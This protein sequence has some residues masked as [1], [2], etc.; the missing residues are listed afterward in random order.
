MTGTAREGI[1]AYNNS[2]ATDLSISSA[3]VTGSTYGIDARNNGSGS[4]SITT[5][6]GTVT[7]KSDDG[8]FA[9]NASK[10]SDLTITTAAVTGSAFG[11]AAINNGTGITSITSKGAV[12]GTSAGGISAVNAVGGTNVT[13]INSAAVTGSTLGIGAI[14]NGTGATSITSSGLVTGSSNGGIYALNSSTATGLTITSAAVTGATRGIDARNNGT[15]AT[16][17]TVNGAVTGSSSKAQGIYSFSNNTTTNNITVN[18]GGSVSA[19]SGKAIVMR[20]TAINSATVNNGG[21][22]TGSVDFGN[23]ANT[24]T[25]NSGGTLNVATGF[26]LTVDG[27]VV[28]NGTIN[29][30]NNV[31]AAPATITGNLSGGGQLLVDVNLVSNT[32]DKLNINGNVTGSTAVSINNI[33]TSP[34]TGNDIT[35]ITVGGTTT[36]GNFTVATGA[37]SGAFNYNILALTGKNWILKSSFTPV[38]S[39]FEAL[40]QNLLTMAKLPSLADRTYSRVGGTGAMGAN[41]GDTSDISTP[42]WVRYAG[43]YR[44]IDSQES[45]TGA[46]FDT[47]QWLAQAGVDLVLSENTN[48]S[49]VLGINTGYNQADTDVESTSGQS[50]IDTKGYNLGLTATWQSA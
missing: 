33:A 50:N 39:S 46:D 2:T 45:T 1:Y 41:S 43:G 5:T 20:G 23:T 14:N 11:I 34:A 21:S 13:I 8:I 31:I 30:R 28:N 27:S 18:N 4:T 47:K 12:T 49:F 19:T 17:I 36:A 37:V 35:L 9:I 44:N 15:G 38:A 48:S 16:S 29:L 22:V 6:A 40:G 25:L 10:A 32:A 42:I 24:L 7:G 26:A 3:A